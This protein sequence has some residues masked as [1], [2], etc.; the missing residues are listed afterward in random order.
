MTS[1]E[2]GPLAG[3]TYSRKDVS[4]ESL[5]DVLDGLRL[6]PEL[7][8]LLEMLLDGSFEKGARVNYHTHYRGDAER[9]TANRLEYE[10]VLAQV[11]DERS[12]LTEDQR[13]LVIDFGVFC[14]REGYNLPRVEDDDAEIIED[15]GTES[16]ERLRVFLDGNDSEEDGDAIWGNE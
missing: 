3:I 10:D 2:Q 12:W 4:I 15:L 6:A 14:F 7:R 16:L 8:D 9:A 13:E 5:E 11:M 1:T